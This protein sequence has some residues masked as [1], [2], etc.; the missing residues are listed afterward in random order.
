MTYFQTNER[1]LCDLILAAVLEFGRDHWAQHFE[2]FSGPNSERQ[3]RDQVLSQLDNTG[4]LREVVQLANVIVLEQS[5]DGMSYIMF[6]FDCGWDWDHGTGVLIHRDQIIKTDM[7]MH[8]LGAI[9]DW[10]FD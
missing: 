9:T 1:R 8:L 10:N 6:D 5:K 2:V 4:G 7:T 3:R